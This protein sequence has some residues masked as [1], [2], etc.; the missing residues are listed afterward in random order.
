MSPERCRL[1]LRLP[2]GS[3]LEA[4]GAESF[5]ERQ[6]DDFLS[7]APAP[8]PD[9]RRT[10]ANQP[11]PE[12]APWPPPAQ[13]RPA[14]PTPAEPRIAWDAITELRGPSLLLRAK[15]PNPASEQDA[16]LVLLACSH[17]ILNNPKPTAT[18]LAKWL[19]GSGYPVGRMDR[20]LEGAVSAGQLLSSGSRRS[21]RYEL[22]ASGRLRALIL[23]DRL[24]AVIQGHVAG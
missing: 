17:K 7:R 15:L 9:Q 20:A 6:R 1:R 11:Q 8:A 23:A 18:Q 24:T 5:V 13:A 12:E 14:A 2:D 16:C 10:Q 22:T 21:R 3:E 4:E 19:R